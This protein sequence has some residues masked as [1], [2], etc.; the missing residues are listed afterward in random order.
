MIGAP[1][2]PPNADA[3]D[4]VAD[5]GNAGPTADVGSTV[6]AAGLSSSSGSDG[7]RPTPMWYLA[8]IIVVVVGVIIALAANAW[9]EDRRTDALEAEVLRAVRS[10]LEANRVELAEIV[11]LTEDCL[12]RTDRFLRAAPSSLGAVPAD[13]A[14]HWAASLACRRTFE[15]ATEAA[16]ALGTAPGFD[17]VL[18]LRI[19][20]AVA[21]WVTALDD[22]VE[23]RNAMSTYG[24]AVYQVLAGYVATAA[25]D[26]IDAF[27]TIPRLV[28]RGG[29]ERLAALRGDTALV[30]RVILRAHYQRAYGQELQEALAAADSALTLLARTGD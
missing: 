17:S 24:D 12:D 10:E 6:E 26:G 20:R 22:A 23:E 25:D 19:R 18:D 9:W 4:P 1:T 7:W 8:E 14:F 21:G 29:G 3:T 13:S 16:Q 30:R 5:A 15:P 11:R 27:P 2:D 28:A